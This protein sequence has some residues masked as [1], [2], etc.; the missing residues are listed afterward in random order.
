MAHSNYGPLTELNQNEE[1]EFDFGEIHVAYD[2]LC[3]ESLKIKV[4]SVKMSRK[5]LKIKEFY[6]AL[7]VKTIDLLNELATLKLDKDF[8]LFFLFNKVKFLNTKYNFAINKNKALMLIIENTR[9]DMIYTNEIF[10]LVS[11]SLME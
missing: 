2:Q 10:D 4:V 11:K 5:A 6:D 7:K 3:K 1:S 9:K 8:F